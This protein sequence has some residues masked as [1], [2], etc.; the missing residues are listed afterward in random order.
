MKK[1]KIAAAFLVL[2]GLAARVFAQTNGTVALTD[3]VY[4]VLENAQLRGLCG[5]LPSVK[6]Y[7]EKRILAA[8][9]EILSGGDTGALSMTE[10]RILEDF[11]ASRAR[12]PEKDLSQMR[13]RLERDAAGVPVSFELSAAVETAFSGGLY[14]DTDLDQWGFDLIPSLNFAGD[15]SRFVSY[16]VT[17]FL[18]L[19]RM[20][21][22]ECGDYFIGYSWYGDGV[23][24]F[25]DG[26]YD[27]DGSEYDEPSPRTVKKFLNTS[28]L[29]YGYGKRWDGQMYFL[30]NMS[31]EGL[32]G[33]PQETGLGFGLTAEIHA[34]VLKDIV[35]ISC[36]RI[37]REWAG[38][39]HGSSLVLNASARP[40]IG[41]ETQIHLFPFLSYSFLTG[42]LEY[43]NQ[44][45]MNE[46]SYA[47]DSGRTDD[48]TFFQNGFS[49]N[50][51]ELDFKY[52]HLDFGSSV[53]WP[54]RFEL[55][56]MFPLLNYVIYQNNIGDYDN[57]ALFGDIKLRKPGL[58]S[59]WASLY[60][61]EINGLNNNPFTSSRAMFAAQF[62]TK[63]AIPRLP[64]AT[65]SL[66][67][68]KVEPYCYTHHSINYTPWYSNYVSE[69]YTN[70]GECLGYYL[71]PNSDEF[72]VRFE[73]R[74]KPNL[75]TSLQYQFIRHGADYGSQQVP[76]SSLYSELSPYNRNDLEKYF[77]RDGAYEWMHIVSVGA[78]YSL[79]NTR[80]P[81]QL[82][83]NAGFLYSYYTVIDQDVYD[84]RGEYGNNGNSGADKNTQFHYIDSEE[85]PV[86]TGVILSLGVKLW[87]R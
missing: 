6:P 76:G 77:L 82:S 68:T 13:L 36:G 32:E 78:V 11:R 12:R 62:G 14:T 61:D 57:H 56:Y 86:R 66:R 23:S 49:I 73:T 30:G 15:L 27:T 59:I 63:V 69:N 38:M 22:Y 42:I 2:F 55:G 34:T 87:C 40:F 20:P 7:T 45:Y 54:K 71:P 33:W 5:A 67:Y 31:A 35:D 47:G 64:F 60:L 52:L 46:N 26:E 72:F 4:A 50:M 81:V 18:D 75:R 70:N 53:I 51:I 84:K 74:P 85:Y 21:L 8:V 79:P 10:K 41:A 16:R 28:Y 29:P 65:L 24:Q 17:G 83:G 58:G 25:I 80:I 39:D 19:T 37:T 43:P 3:A 1:L 44:D 48:S 9:D